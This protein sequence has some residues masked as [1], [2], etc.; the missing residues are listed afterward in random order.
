MS[1]THVLFELP[2]ENSLP[3]SAVCLEKPSGSF[4]AA[5]EFGSGPEDNRETEPSPIVFD[6]RTTDW[7]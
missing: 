7:Y 3:E 5:G 6:V 1:L 2:I 4:S